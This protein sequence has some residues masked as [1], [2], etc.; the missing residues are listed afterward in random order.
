MNMGVVGEGGEINN[1]TEF[2]HMADC[3]LRW[4]HKIHIASMLILQ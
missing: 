1:P 4:I 3:W 2:L